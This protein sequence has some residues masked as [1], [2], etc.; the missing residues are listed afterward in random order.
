MDRT[1]GVTIAI[2]GIALVS[3]S[4]NET[5]KVSS[6]QDP[7]LQVET[8]EEPQSMASAEELVVPKV[9]EVI[10]DPKVEALTKYLEESLPSLTNASTLAQIQDFYKT[11]SHELAW[12][13]EEQQLSVYPPTEGLFRAIRSS[14]THGLNP[15]RYDSELLE[16][17][18]HSLL[19]TNPAERTAQ[20]L[21]ENDVLLTLILH[22]FIKDLRYGHV[23]PYRAIG[24]KWNRHSRK[25]ALHD[26]INLILKLQTSSEIEKAIL[27]LAPHCSAYLELRNQLATYQ[28]IV[29]QRA[30]EAIPRPS[31]RA[32]WTIEPGQRFSKLP[33]LK[34]RLRAT[35]EYR[36]SREKSEDPTSTRYKGEIVEAVKKFQQRHSLYVDGI[37]GPN[38]LRE[39]NVPAEKRIEQILVNLERIRWMPRELGNRYIMVNVPEFTLRAYDQ[40]Q[41]VENMRVVVGSMKKR[42]T[43]PVI[44]K[45]MKHIIFRPYW[46]VPFSIS[47]D[48]LIPAAEANENYLAHYHY[49]IICNE[50][51][52]VIE[53]LEAGLELVKTN[54]AYIRQKSGSFNALGHVK[55]IF[56]NDY[57]VYMHDTNETRYFDYTQRDFSHGCIRL[58]RPDDLA[59]YALGSVRNWD[60][61]KIH[62]MMYGEKRKYVPLK[63][64]IEVYIYYMT[65]FYADEEREFRFC[66]D[67]YEHD[68][69]VLHII[70]KKEHLALK[71]AS[72]Q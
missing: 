1:R 22:T 31:D 43:T 8:V 56:P 68:S 60:K 10:I 29:N 71:L 63:K 66:H 12:S 40:G 67:I 5:N 23:N 19:K 44:H 54:G 70:Q 61:E 48:E 65:A 21:A 45:P 72:T 39:L 3:C 16:A 9:P 62:S 7:M 41:Q 25:V 42:T 33:L 47:R 2:L 37:L 24:Q 53:D 59:V 13:L 49:E 15:E 11:N 4:K 55:F 27:S 28:K 38:T 57:S 46:N 26:H 30:W 34:K 51:Q 50:D 58:H 64:P 69:R 14:S 36:H 17:N 32:D 20:Q 52:R 35:G 18:L 6:T